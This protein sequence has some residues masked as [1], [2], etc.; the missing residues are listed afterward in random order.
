[1]RSY[2]YA[3]HAVVLL[4]ATAISSYGAADLTLSATRQGTLN[5]QAAAESQSGDFSLKAAPM[6]L[7]TAVGQS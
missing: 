7:R 4:L 2:R 5:A 6:A 3:S 1:M